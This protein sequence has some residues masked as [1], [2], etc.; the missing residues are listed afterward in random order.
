MHN[1][2]CQESARLKLARFKFF[3]KIFHLKYFLYLELF[4]KIFRDK[5]VKYL[6][7]A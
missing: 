7:L 4:A 3:P 1:E 5:S 2:S 6:Q